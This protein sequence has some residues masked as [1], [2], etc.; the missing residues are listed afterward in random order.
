MIGGQTLPPGFLT[1][2]GQAASDG[3]A[4][5]VNAEGRLPPYGGEDALWPG[6]NTCQCQY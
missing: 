6:A 1:T 3:Y 5:A 2:V 4:I